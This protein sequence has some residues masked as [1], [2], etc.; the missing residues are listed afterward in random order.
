MNNNS[1]RY[2]YAVYTRA[3]WEKRV[4]RLFEQEGICHYLP[5]YKTVRLW[6]DRKKS[7]IMPL[8]PSYVFVKISKFDYLKVLNTPGVA[9]IISF[10]GSPVAIPEKQIQTIKDILNKGVD[11]EAVENL[12]NPGD[13][14]EVCKGSLK[15]LKGELVEYRGK[16]KIA[17]R[18]DV[19]EKSIIINIPLS[20][21]KVSKKLLKKINT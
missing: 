7:V 2:W 19:I 17:I 11:I 14:M 13:E 21:A 15:G 3:R 1:N 16:K 5:L 9:R 12:P 4:S 8:F 10:E 6:S 18:L 20:H